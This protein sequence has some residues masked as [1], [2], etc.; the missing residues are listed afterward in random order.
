MGYVL[1]GRAALTLN[2]NRTELNPG[3]SVYIKESLPQSWEN[4]GMEPLRL[5]WLELPI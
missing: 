4:L 1:N 2:G 5:L 3:D